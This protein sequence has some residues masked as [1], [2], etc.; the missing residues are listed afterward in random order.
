VVRG[1]VRSGALASAHDTSEGGL[2][3]ALA[4]C[5]IADKDAMLGASVELSPGA[6]APHAY[7]FGEDASRVVVSFP[8]AFQ[9]EVAAACQR[10][11]VPCAVLGVVG[12]DRLTVPGLFD[13]PLTQLSRAW[14]SAIPGMMKQPVL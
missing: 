9:V 12:G 2:A 1:L 8:P 4:E 13:V 6:I 7:L 5:C 14:R 11:G 3:V 10:A